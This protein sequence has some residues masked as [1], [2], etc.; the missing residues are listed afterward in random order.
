MKKIVVSLC[1]MG[2]LFFGVEA[3]LRVKQA[4]PWRP[5]NIK[6][7]DQLK[8]VFTERMYSVSGGM[9]SFED[10]KLLVDSF[11]TEAET[12]QLYVIQYCKEHP[13]KSLARLLLQAIIPYAVYDF[14]YQVGVS[15]QQPDKAEL[16]EVVKDMHDQAKEKFDVE[17]ELTALVQL[18]QKANKAYYKSLPLLTRAYSFIFRH[19]G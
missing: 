9:L 8:K 15:R 4:D 14:R 10:Y 17:A 18:V 12:K 6:T 11:L 16:R 1:V 19:F 7:Y 2:L 5:L 3:G 13:Q